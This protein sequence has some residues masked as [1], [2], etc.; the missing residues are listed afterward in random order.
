MSDFT[1]VLDSIV[2][3][4]GEPSWLRDLRQAALSRFEQTPVP[5]K[6]DEDWRRVDVSKFLIEGLSFDGGAASSSFSKAEAFGLPEGAEPKASGPE[7]VWMTT[8]SRAASERPEL[9][10]PCLERSLGRSASRFHAL[11][12]ALWN[13]GIFIHVPDGVQA[14]IPLTA[15][16]DAS[17]KASGAGRPGALPRTLAVL[18]RNSRAVFLFNERSSETE[19]SWITG[20]TEVHLQ[21]GASLSWLQVQDFGRRATVL[22]SFFADLE[23][24]SSLNLMAVESGSALAKSGW[25]VRIA[26]EGASA[27]LYGLVRG[28]GTQH[29]DETLFVG[30]ERPHS[31]SEVLFKT[32]VKDKSRSIFTGLIHVAKA[33]QKTNAYQ[34]NRNLILGKD[35]RADA[36]P[37]LEIEA[38][39][40]KCGHGA[41][42]SNIDPDQLYY[43]MS[44][45]LTRGAAEAMIIAG[46]YE[47][48]LDK[49]MENGPFASKE[50][51]RGE[52]SRWVNGVLLG[53]R[54]AAEALG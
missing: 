12:N 39:D 40:V 10:R 34:T 47:D 30:H 8:I 44:R 16:I 45:G 51:E 42:V 14:E 33:A 32:A 13:G 19:E 38:D 52:L 7:G 5:S 4:N 27:K 35:A 1:P 22:S 17:R 28:E 53:E 41:A 2:R 11:C 36:I 49:W 15:L 6:T 50:Q 48:V 37:K 24:D 20:L 46:F 54:E 43:L 26:G 25:S 29:F 18:G 23:R 21:A 31:E 9:V 3:S